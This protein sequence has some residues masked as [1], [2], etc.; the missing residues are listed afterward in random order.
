MGVDELTESSVG[1]N[2][3]IIKQQVTP[4]LLIQLGQDF[5]QWQAFVDDIA[6]VGYD[7]YFVNGKTLSERV[8]DGGS[9][10]PIAMGTPKAS[11]IDGF[12]FDMDLLR[13]N[14]AIDGKDGIALA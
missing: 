8:A 11:H 10:S 4:S 13:T 5:Q 9:M 2:Q 6:D 1:Y 12:N 14:K 3:Y 7:I